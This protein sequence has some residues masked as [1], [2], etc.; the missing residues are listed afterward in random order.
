MH[1][2]RKRYVLFDIHYLSKPIDGRKIFAKICE[3][4]KTVFGIIVYSSANIKLIEYNQNSHIG[5]IRVSH[6]YVE[7]LRVALALIKQI[8]DEEVI[9]HVHKVSGTL[10]SLR[11][12]KNN[13]QYSSTS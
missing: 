2:L 6:R 7:N 12:S 3:I 10:K 5:I 11:E 1:R 8:G 9:F 4:F 13:M